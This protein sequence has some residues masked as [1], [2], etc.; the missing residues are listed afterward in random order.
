MVKIS[1]SIKPNNIDIDDYTV[2]FFITR[3]VPKP[4]MPIDCE[5]DYL[6]MIEQ[7]M[8]TK[9]PIVNT[10]INEDTKVAQSDKENE[11]ES[12][13][14]GESKKRTKKVSSIFNWNLN[15]LLMSN[16]YRKARSHLSMKPISRRSKTSSC[17][18]NS[19]NACFLNLCVVAH[20]ASPFS[21]LVHLRPA[22]QT[23]Q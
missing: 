12:D 15:A 22:S 10:T 7:A 1:S 17:F 16:L 14:D 13:K 21:D 9:T 5:G 3:L 20:I 11:D 8:K 19:G 4:G 6:F 18:M 23:S 2:L